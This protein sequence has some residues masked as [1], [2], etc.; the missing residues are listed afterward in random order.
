M[1]AELVVL[2]RID[3]LVQRA[4]LRAAE[5]SKEELKLMLGAQMKARGTV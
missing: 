4:I 1:A 5:D 2:Q 3:P